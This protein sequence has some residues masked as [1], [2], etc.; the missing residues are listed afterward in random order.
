MST[1][2]GA[3]P[4]TTNRRKQ[5]NRQLYDLTI[6]PGETEDLAKSKPDLVAELAAALHKA[7]TDGRTRD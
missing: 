4:D 2:P 1:G 7:R 5:K 6:D 3:S